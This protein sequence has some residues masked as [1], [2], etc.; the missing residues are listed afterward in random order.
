MYFVGSGALLYQAV[1][2]SVASGLRVECVCCPPADSAVARL[3]KQ[4][5][6]VVESTQP[7]ETLRTIIE[8]G[9]DGVVFSINN[10]HIIAD[11]LLIRGARF[12]NV[13][14]G[15][16]Q[17]YR[18]IAEVCIF[19][20][21]CTGDLR[22]GATLQQLLPGQEV[23]AGPAVAQLEFPIGST[24]RFCDVLPRSLA[25]CQRVFEMNVLGIASNSSKTVVLE[26]A[27]A[28]LGYRDVIALCTEADPVRLGLASDLG[29]Y[30]GFFP[31][32]RSL[33]DSAR[34]EYSTT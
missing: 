3:R 18:G 26:T 4:G 28:V 10:R 14:N 7:N 11:E 24:D 15:L 21:V 9:A 27:A 22:Y 31:R 8:A 33:I 30:A 17:R 29:R 32:L 20:A 5:V 23:D 16:V 1:S 2:F 12:F 34:Q 6:A 25:A 13:H 19:A